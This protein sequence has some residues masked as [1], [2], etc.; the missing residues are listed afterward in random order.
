M[1]VTNHKTIKK[2]N[3]STDIIIAPPEKVLLTAT[4]ESNTIKITATKS[5]IINTPVT[6]SVNF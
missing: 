6:T 1:P 4:V 3:L 2:I 5:S